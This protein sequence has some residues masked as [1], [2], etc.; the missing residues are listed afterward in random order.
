[1]SG[2]IELL[3]MVGSRCRRDISRLVFRRR[4]VVQG[5]IPYISF[6]F[7]D[8]PKSALDNG[9]SVLK[10][11]GVRGTYYASLGLTGKRNETGEIFLADDLKRVLEDGHELGCH[12]YGHCH[13]W[14]TSPRD[15]RRSIQEN[16]QALARLAAGAKFRTFSY[17]VECPRPANKRSA[18]KSFLCSRGGGQTFNRG[19]V[20]SNLL[21]AFFLEQGRDDP[22][23]IKRLITQNCQANGWLI[24]ATHDVQEIPSIYGC[25]TSFFREIV[26][27]SINS[28]ARV[29]PVVEAYEAIASCAPSCVSLPVG[30]G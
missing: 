17:P 2:I 28:G 8:F 30:E 11:L 14:E 20:D 13:A 1:M 24:F 16:R 4:F 3:Q 27:H 18:S 15:F 25:T 9:G 23:A 10:E 29:I 19:V 7:D 5:S 21:L 22:M 26:E 12:T 6:T